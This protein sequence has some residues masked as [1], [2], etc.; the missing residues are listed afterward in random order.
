MQ[1][2][3]L[4]FNMSAASLN[5]SAGDTGS[6]GQVTGLGHALAEGK[7][8]SYVED[9]EDPYMQRTTAFLLEAQELYCQTL[10]AQTGVFGEATLSGNVASFANFSLPIVRGIIPNLIASEIASLQPM[11]G[12]AGVIFFMKVVAGSTKGGT[13]K[14]TE[15]SR[16][17]DQN[18]SSEQVETEVIGTGDTVEVTFT[19]T[20]SYVPIRPN[21]LSATDGTSTATDDGN[22]N[23]T[24][25]GIG[26]GTIDYATGAISITFDAA[27]AAVAISVDYRFDMEGSESVPEVDFLMTSSPVIARARKLR[28]RY[29]LESSH[30]MRAVHGLDADSE[31]G[32][33]LV[34][35]LRFEIDREVID[36]ITTIAD[37]GTVSFDD[38]PS[39]G[40]GLD[41]H[42]RSFKK[43]LVDAGGLI[44]NATK[45]A[46]GN[47]VI[48]GRQTA[49][50]IEVLPGFVGSGIANQHGVA[51]MGTIDG[52]WTAYRDSYKPAAD[53]LV[54]HKGTS[55]ME[56]GYVLAMYVP[57]FA[58]PSVT[59]DD[60]LTRRGMG[61]IYGKKAVDGRYFCTGSIT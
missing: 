57:L 56:T 59:L 6:G 33:H 18:Y 12:P 4:P 34:Q 15:L 27:P 48:A 5:E 43:T 45:R 11:T 28:A 60:F 8:R 61:S 3:V 16:N 46:Q 1:I 32:T 38:T 10:E 2:P 42:L 49:D 47:W 14:G 52:R 30:N 20:L 36:Q 51:N 24:G 53:F 35:E 26:A 17:P 19:G 41:E 31:V 23:L 29:S 13:A 40:L 7:W 50:I 22:G 54:G 21:T 44:Y 55:F 37:A 58:T 39:A 9:I 25:T